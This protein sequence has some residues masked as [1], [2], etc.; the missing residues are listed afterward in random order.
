MLVVKI[1]KS[2][3]IQKFHSE[4]SKFKLKDIQFQIMEE[5]KE[6]HPDKTDAE[7]NDIVKNLLQDVP[8]HTTYPIVHT[9]WQSISEILYCST[10]TLF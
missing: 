7:V 5:I 9:G 6:N 8:Q 10:A 1:L 2:K 3:S 4:H